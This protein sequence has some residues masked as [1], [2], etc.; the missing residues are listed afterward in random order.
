VTQS[1]IT[2]AVA[3]SAQVFDL[4][5]TAHGQLSLNVAHNGYGIIADPS[6]VR[7]RLSDARTTIANAIALMDKIDWHGVNRAYDAEYAGR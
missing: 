2:K 3:A 5:E 4:I 6:T 1:I 7:S